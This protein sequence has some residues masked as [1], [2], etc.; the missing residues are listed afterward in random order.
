MEVLEDRVM[1]DGVPDGTLDP[2]AISQ[3]EPLFEATADGPQTG[4]QSPESP[5]SAK[6][7]V[8]VDKRVAGY[9]P[10]VADLTSNRESDVVFLNKQIDTL[11]QIADA[12][13][14][15]NQVDGTIYDAVH[16]IETA[17]E[18]NAA[19]DVVT[20]D[21][22]T[23][24]AAAA[25]HSG[26]TNDPSAPNPAS[27]VLV[28]TVRTEVVV[29]DSAV[30]DAATMLAGLQGSA[31]PSTNWIVVRIDPS[32]DGI[33]QIS[34]TLARQSSVDALHLI[35]HGDGR[36]IDLGDTFLD[37]DSLSG[38][39]S[40]IALW[41]DALSHDADILIYGCD[42]ASTADG[43][44][45]VEA[46]AALTAAD[47]AA[48]DDATGHELLG[49]DWQLEYVLGTIDTT[50]LATSWSF[51][52][53][54]YGTLATITGTAG[55]DILEGTAAGDT[56]HGNGGNDILLGGIDLIDEGNFNSSATTTQMSVSGSNSGWTISAG[57]VDFLA[58]DS[59]IALPNDP[60][61]ATLRA[62]D[63]NDATI[64]RTVAGL[65]IGKTY[66]L[67]FFMAADGESSQ[68]LEVGVVGQAMETMQVSMP[69]GNTL[70][71]I[72]WQ[73]KLHTFTATATSHTIQFA[74][75]S[76][77]VTAG[78][79][80]AGVRMVD[81][82]ASDGNDTIYG[83]DGVDL[84]LAGGGSDSIY[85]DDDNQQDLIDGGDGA[86]TYYIESDNT[87]DLYRDSGKTGVDQLHLT[88]NADS[89][90]HIT[91]E[92]S[93]ALSGIDTI[94]DA[95]TTSY[96]TT[97]GSSTHASSVNWDF[98]GITLQYVEEIHGGMQD[99]TITFDYAGVGSPTTIHGN[100]GNDTI[101]TGDGNETIYGGSGHDIIDAGN[102][103]NTVN[104]DDGNDRL[105][106]G[107]GRDTICGGN[108]V[109]TVLAGAGNDNLCVAD[110]SET[111]IVDGGD[112]AD[113]YFLYKNNTP[114]IYCDSGTD[115]AIDA[116]Y[117]YS[118]GESTYYL[119][120]TF[121]LEKTG[122]DSIY[123][124]FSYSTTYLGSE[125]HATALN[126]DFRGILFFGVEN[127]RG[128]TQ[129]DT[130]QTDYAG[131]D[132]PT[133][134]YGY[135]GNDTIM[136]GNAST[137]IYGG[138]GDDLIDA[139]GGT[140]TVYG[141]AGND[142]L[143][144]GDNNDTIWGGD[145]DDAIYGGRGGDTMYGDAGNDY[146]EGGT[147]NDTMY[148]GDGD[149]TFDGGTGTGVDITHGE[150]GID[151]VRYSDPVAN[152]T[153][154]YA[155]YN[156]TDPSGYVRV[157][158]NSVIGQDEG[159][160]NDYGTVEFARFYD[161]TVAFLDDSFSADLLTTFDLPVTQ[162]LYENSSLLFNAANGNLIAVADDPGE[163]LAI[164]LAVSHGV[165]SLGAR[166]PGISFTEN[167]GILDQSMTFSG[168][169]EDINI[170]LDGLQFVPTTNFNGDTT[171]TLTA[172]NT[173][174]SER[175]TNRLTLTVLPVNSAP[176]FGDGTTVFDNHVVA[177]NAVG[178]STVTTADVDGDGDLDI[179]S[180]ATTANEVAWF[181]NDGH[182][183]FVAHSISTS[184]AGVRSVAAADLDNDGDIDILAAA[185]D[186]GEIIWF[187]ND[188]NQSFSQ[189]TV[190]TL[191]STATSIFVVDLD[192]DG[193]LDVL[194]TAESL[195][196]VA[197]YENDGNENFSK[198]VIA[199]DADGAA[200]VSSVDL[201]QDG[202][203][204]ILSASA[205]DNTI[206]WYENDGGQSFT[207]R[208]VSTASV[209][210]RAVAF[211]D[212]DGDGDID[213][214]STSAASQALVWHEND[215]DENFI[216]HTIT[217]N[218]DGAVSVSTADIDGDG[219]IDVFSASL[220]D[221]KIAWFQN[222]GNQNF[223][224]FS[225][226]ETASAA[227]AVTAADI[228]GDGDI[229]IVSAAS[230]ND[231]IAWHENH[232]HKGLGRSVGY[233]EGEPA[234]RLAPDLEVRDPELEETDCGCG[235][236]SGATV[237]LARDIEPKSEDL[238]S[239][240]D[241][242][243]ITRDGTMLLKRGQSIASFDLTTPGQLV[244]TFTDANGEVPSLKDVNFI[245]SQIAYEITGNEMPEHVDMRW[246]FDDGNSGGQGDGGSLFTTG[247][248][249]VVFTEVNDEQILAVKTGATIAEGSIGN[250]ITTAMLQTTDLDNT[251]A[252]IVYTIDGAPT[253][254]TLFRDGVALSANDTFTQS[255]IDA[256][257][258]RFDH[259]GSEDFSDSFDFT[260]DDGEGA[261]T[262]AGFTWLV[263]SVNDPP[264]AA[265]IESAPLSYTENQGA[266]AISS[267][268]TVADVDDTQ[269]ESAVVAI[270]AGYDAGQDQLDFV[271]QNGIVGAWDSGTG[272]LTLTG[273]ATVAQ[274]Q[275]ALRS[276]T[277]TNTSEQPST[278]NRTVSVH[279]NDGDRDGNPQS[280]EIAITAVNDL[281]TFVAPGTPI[282]TR[283]NITT[284]ADGATSVSTADVDGDG[285][286]DVLTTSHGD[287][288]VAWYE[289]D[290]SGNFTR[291]AVSTTAG[292]PTS[293]STADIDGDG[294]L[295]ILASSHLSDRITW[296][297]NNGSQGFTARVITS[298]TDFATSVSTADIDGDGDID[299]L[300]S[301]RNDDKIAW[302]EN[303]GN[304]NFTTHVITKT[305]D[306]VRS[307]TTADVDGDGDIDI[308]YGS[309]DNNTVAWHENDGNQ[310]F[311]KHVI[312]TEAIGV[313]NI[314]VADVDSDGD[315]DVLSALFNG[316]AV[317][318]H[319]N[320]GSGNFTTHV[321]TTTTDSASS[322]TAA[323]LDGDG[324]IDVLSTSY[325]DNTVAW[326]ENNGTENFTKHA[327][328]TNARGAISVTTADVNGDGD[329]DILY[330]S[331]I[332]NTIAWY[333]SDPGPLVNTLDGNPTFTEDGP[334][335]VLDANVKIF[336]AELTVLNDFGG[337]SL[338]L[339]S[340][341]GA[342]PD[343]LF[344]ATGNLAF[345][346]TTTGNIE[347]SSAVI[348]TYSNTA[349]TLTLTFAAGV[350]NAQVNAAIQSIAYANSSDTPPASVQ[351]D[352]TFDDGN[353]GDQGTGG[354]QQ[355]IGSTTID[356]IATNDDPANTGS[357]PNQI[358][359]T[360]DLSG[361]VDLSLIDLSDSDAGSS[362]LTVTLT[363]S[364][365]GNLSAAA[366][367]GIT[368]GGTSTVRTLTGSLTDL[369]SYLN[370][371]S[372]ITYLHGTP[373]TNGDAADTIQIHVTD[374]G[375]SGSGGGG[376]VD[377]GTFDVDITAV[378]DEQVLAVNT[379][380]TVAEGST[381]NTITTAM[382][383]TTDVDNT[384]V[385]L[386]YTVDSIAVNGTL[387]RN[388]VALSASDTFSQADI[389]AG[390]ITYDHNGSQT[391][392]D[393][394]TFTV[395]DGTGTTTSASFNWTITNVNDAPVLASIEGTSLAHTENDGA[396]AI[397]STLTLADDDDTNIES[398]L[399]TISA[400]YVNGQDL[401]AFVDQ[402]GING[403]WNVGTGT[404]TMTGT[405][406][407]AQYQ[408]ALRS[409][410]YSNS[411][412]LPDTTS[413]TVSFTVNDGD[414]NSNTVSRNIAV[415]SI[416]DDPTNAG[417][418]PSDVTVTEDVL[419]SIDLSAIDLSDVDHNGGYLTLTL[420]TSTGGKLTATTSGGVT[421][422]DSGSM[423][424]S[425]TGT[426]AN[427]NT[428]LNTTTAIKYQ[429]ATTDLNGNDADTISVAITDNGNTGNGGG[430]TIDLGTFNVDITAVND[431]QVLAVNT[432]AT[433]A[434]GSTGNTITTAMLQTTDVDNTNVQLV[435]T[436]D[437][438]P[439]YGTLYRNA[440][441]LSANDTFTQADIAAGLITYDH[442]SSQTASDSFT[443]TVD[444]GTGTTT[445]ASF[446]WA[447]TN[448]NDA[449]VLA[450]IESA[451]IAYTENDGAVAITSTLTLSDDDLENLESAVV[452]VTAGYN[453]DQDILSLADQNG[454]S[455]SW[456]AG[457]GTLTLTGSATI[458]QYQAALRSVT[459]TNSSERPDTAT[460]TVSI[461]VNDGEH[462]SNTLTR[463]ITVA[464]V[465]D[466]PSNTGSFP[467]TG[468]VTEDVSSTIDLSSIDLSDLDH[469]G[470][471]LV[472]T[473]STSNG[474]T[475]TDGG[476]P[477]LVRAPLDPT[478]A[479]FQG[480]LN[481]L[482]AFLDNVGALKY[483]HPTQ[484]ISG[485]T[486][487]AITVTIRDLGNTGTGGGGTILLGTFDVDIT[488]V[489]DEQILAVNTGTTVA[490]GSTG[491]TIT[492]A[493][494]QT[495][496]VDN[497][498]AQLVY[499]VDSIPVNGT[500]YRNAVALSASDT[501]TQADIAAGLIT[502]DHNDSQTATDGF[503]FTVDDGTGTTTSAAFHWTVTNVNDAPVAVSDPVVP[504][505][506]AFIT[507]ETTSLARVDILSNDIDADHDPLTIVRINGNTFSVG[508]PITL[509]SGALVT[510]N[511]DGTID[512]DPNGR[513]DDLAVGQSALDG[514]AYTISDGQGGTDTGQVIVTINGENEPP[515]IGDSKITIDPNTPTVIPVLENAYDSN[516][517]PLSVIVISQ[518][519]NASVV[520]NSDGTL[521]F[522][523][524]K[525][526]V[527]T[528]SFR[529]LV[530]DPY[531]GSATA[532]LQVEVRAQFVFDNLHQPK[533]GFDRD[534]S[535][536][537]A[538]GGINRYGSQGGD[539]VYAGGSVDFRQPLSQQI[540]TLAPEPILSGQARYGSHIVGRIYDSS[541][542]LIA[543]SFTIADISGTWL[544][545]FQGVRSFDYYRVEIELTDNYGHDSSRL[546]IGPSNSSYQSL[547]PLTQ[548][549]E[550]LTVQRVTRDTPS[551]SLQ[552]AHRALNNPLG[553]GT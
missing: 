93:Q 268:L 345:V 65:T 535:G 506:P 163:Q 42:L 376:I 461:T 326:Y 165:L 48:S 73:V 249:T 47:V 544:L 154:D 335:V 466:D 334:P 463:H 545:Q 403:S 147:S 125:L 86:D 252:E 465:N 141:E 321:I 234:V 489:N 41:G 20:I 306:G 496:D 497:T 175:E 151:T 11:S 342:S 416:N 106:T 477:G 78:A 194:S 229:D 7:I 369:N 51:D 385:Q 235:N 206:A 188:G 283:H 316:K 333:G 135:G 122:I 221:N 327:I 248:T 348:G 257:L 522:T 500:L 49:G 457:T 406:T 304:G 162:T 256:G 139:G 10:L 228:D 395:D 471:D 493:M 442:N 441:A 177:S 437:S 52:V 434:E 111:D 251:A 143:W 69:P 270:T 549:S 55:A 285:D 486:A 450:S 277:Y 95:Y 322:V 184:V 377:L 340:N 349:G 474:G 472:L 127:I 150:A 513:F 104:G 339:A 350:T 181:E 213:L 529:Y 153:L 274:Y 397:T 29:I 217:T 202:D 476:T 367:A 492:T 336:D 394:F 488:T 341:G 140:D 205:N 164:T 90:Y 494:L 2:A 313:Y 94:Y 378:N 144:G 198:H 197:W 26:E 241:G 254:G 275:S 537:F 129:D 519:D 357:L 402:N 331:S 46:I 538:A 265:D 358:S 426:L 487:D 264:V 301:S 464:S 511:G 255:D 281:P 512:F 292:G 246:T 87:A 226:S 88:S 216:A 303:D 287:N 366:A 35:G 539:S 130:I 166:P 98:T 401:L 314:A 117:L 439:V 514:F 396:A 386:V 460:R 237:T 146:I 14:D 83:G 429:H 399:V 259:N 236:F 218:V 473:I 225:I 495:T 553:L 220:A 448:V 40:D 546:S 291:H 6:Q 8:F 293:I 250:T 354:P 58:S 424:L 490:E 61:D 374:N 99:D 338:T 279:V 21:P 521:T 324:D 33:Q 282:F 363:T 30:Q 405:A 273:T 210:A 295:D 169:L 427:L 186:D 119:P 112:G 515:Q 32:T 160:N 178:A 290:G 390:L 167:D 53:S 242:N 38:Y 361:E 1:F 109:D 75:T 330:A 31:D 298:S 454:I 219:D 530:E 502:Y 312:T 208:I 17:A 185:Y 204:D 364:T 70:A 299:V 409:I 76:G 371:S 381:G 276:V 407:L 224:E 64:S 415:A 232:I 34:D 503:A 505:N 485:T 57:N 541:G 510:V 168:S 428:Y 100:E 63:L 44:T 447:I 337:A 247:L 548:T 449:P 351:I 392:S 263:T 297:E 507:N 152:Y 45:L 422:A 518:P 352:W 433:V 533:N 13:A 411:S 258:I 115:G 159:D 440:V 305:A 393:S 24:T 118:T 329:I 89:T 320:D 74:A 81:S 56:I 240:V 37:V 102:G 179:I 183:S 171:L 446:N 158:D 360:E 425:L 302:Y 323:D 419:S 319:E 359:V 379:G 420:T 483:K 214:L 138:D 131:S 5:T 373:D 142:I 227:K 482:N 498:N 145:G 300:S 84:I 384:N 398:A 16:L 196:E 526:Y 280:R 244:I 318:W 531:G 536:R 278:A 114:D 479:L 412:E 238:F 382:L 532:T 193:D 66:N 356:I 307:A 508:V 540:Y 528:V 501:F 243:G 136:D 328:T 542:R 315:I 149:D 120:D 27:G 170:A 459:Y 470:G 516:G 22:A 233:I 107:S 207:K 346:G 475:L 203:L 60:N 451:V 239:F 12:L 551:L 445:S 72:D 430:G 180:G 294:D 432:G 85:A 261:T 286:I 380:T 187:E 389:A 414:N 126:W 284:N 176:A 435:Y 201:D 417:S 132:G 137:T 310:N 123:D 444:D 211:A 458:A 343:D 68:T 375:N 547:Q 230:G 410:T 543:E 499:T 260:V 173:T 387:Y 23:I 272:T 92:F 289:N 332:D 28:A 368:V 128:G 308:V 370:T 50:I 484:H 347:F 267:T 133:T 355:A 43:R 174:T 195:D 504:T 262:S 325:F 82:A 438:L 309:R 296:Y 155:N 523:P 96:T 148:G 520:V 452:Q 288:T 453:S 215:G 18:G 91:D 253:N 25:V 110:D 134:I 19:A 456:N 101:T 491:N 190:S 113:I 36:G 97:L 245:L 191:A 222:D 311:T 209:A 62:V 3:D 59:G 108:G 552:Q 156:G 161:G 443:F 362:S 192:A 455:S 468:T 103:D 80:I 421:V 71:N 39:A 436:V 344:S 266:V 413:R 223:T 172:V 408:S 404:L 200:A 383:Q 4:D 391:A 199:N 77:T 116:L 388:A 212:L 9:E 105:T 478:I 534:D 269:L 271:D 157:S 525:D 481:A 524:H 317:V 423:T 231:T 480:S 462:E 550:P 400:G 182:G 372:N 431:E 79:I 418:L 54:W 517:D 469:N 509:P 527:G 67:A 353:M 189:R 365:G 121:S 15:R 467:T 124:V